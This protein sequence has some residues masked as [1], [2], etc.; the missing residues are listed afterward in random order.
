[1]QKGGRGCS[2]VTLRGS[3][4]GRRDAGF[5]LGTLLGRRRRSANDG[6]A[7][8]GNAGVGLVDAVE[9]G[10]LDRRVGDSVGRGFGGRHS[11]DDLGTCHVA[12]DAAQTA[13]VEGTGLDGA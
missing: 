5:D 1:M 9:R 3:R 11:R 8:V 4:Q 12:R 2:L 7:N 13:E 6:L 10:R